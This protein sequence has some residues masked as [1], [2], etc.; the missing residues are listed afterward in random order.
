MERLTEM[1]YTATIYD[2]PSLS[3]LLDRDDRQERIRFIIDEWPLTKKN[4]EVNTIEELVRV[5]IQGLP[6]CKRIYDS[7][8]EAEKVDFWNKVKYLDDMLNPV[9]PVQEFILKN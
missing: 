3:Q 7:M 8:S 6:R 4:Y 1:A 5:E 9:N 2:L